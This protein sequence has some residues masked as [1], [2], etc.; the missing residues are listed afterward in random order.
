MKKIFQ[1]FDQ[2]TQVMQNQ[3]SVRNAYKISFIQKLVYGADVT[4]K[5]YY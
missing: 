2:T 4:I 5:T 1:M 3:T